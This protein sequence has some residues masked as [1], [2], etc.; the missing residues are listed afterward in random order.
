[1][2]TRK[3]APE[4]SWDDLE[5]DARHLGGHGGPTC[6][7]ASFLGDVAEKYGQDAADSIV[8]VMGNHRLTMSSIH[9]AI[10]ARTG[11]VQLPSVYTFQ[12]HRSGRCACPREAS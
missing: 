3:K 4:P 10:E 5:N 6:G 12:R 2:P 9:K 1:M 7:V 8:R 11:R